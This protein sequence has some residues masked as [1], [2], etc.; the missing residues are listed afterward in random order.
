MA[1][2]DQLL[3]GDDGLA[4]AAVPVFGEQMWNYYIRSYPDLVR[5]HYP[6]SV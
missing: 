4:G 5:A 3:D 1:R 2:R 6:D